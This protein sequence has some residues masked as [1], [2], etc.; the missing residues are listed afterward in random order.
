M[1]RLA[2]NAVILIILAVMLFLVAM[3]WISVHQDGVAPSPEE[4]DAALGGNRQEVNVSPPGL[5]IPVAGIRPNQLSDTFTQARAGGRRVHDA[6]DIMAPRGTAVIAAAAGTVERLF[7]S[8]GGGGI[9]VYVRSPDGAWI[10]YYAHLDGYAPG[11]H[12][13]QRLAQGDAIGRVGSTGNANDAAPH[14]HF[15]IMRMAPN[16][17]WWQGRAINP[18]PLLAGRRSPR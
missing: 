4:I 5:I 9:T 2:R 18:Y 14:L 10:Y 15:A 3:I 11:L 13:G 6:I 7:F 1:E 8:H 17:R 16:E 12:E